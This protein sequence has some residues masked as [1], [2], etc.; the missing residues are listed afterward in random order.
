MEQYSSIYTVQYVGLC[1]CEVRHVS[2][3]LLGFGGKLLGNLMND[4]AYHQAC[5]KVIVYPRPETTTRNYCNLQVTKHKD[6]VTLLS[7]VIFP[8]YLGMHAVNH[9]LHHYTLECI[10]ISTLLTELHLQIQCN[11]V[12]DATEETTLGGQNNYQFFFAVNYI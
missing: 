6:L 1:P 5:T 10:L 9:L 7:H 2:Y 12:I 3:C 8:S 11:S 4:S